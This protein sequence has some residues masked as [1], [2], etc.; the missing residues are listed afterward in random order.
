M[1]F[2]SRAH[3][4]ILTVTIAVLALYSLARAKTEYR[5]VQLRDKTK[6]EFAL[7]APDRIDPDASY[8]VLLALPPGPQHR[9]TVDWG[10]RNMYEKQ[11][12]KRGWI[13]VSPIAPNGR[14]FFSGSEQYIPELLALIAEEF[15]VAGGKFHVAGISNGGISVFRVVLDSPELFHSLIAMPGFP[16]GDD[17]KRLSRLKHLPVRMFVGQHDSGWVDAMQRSEKALR[18]M[19]TDVSLQ[20]VAGEGHQIGSL[21]GGQ[22]LFDLLDG[23]HDR[24]SRDSK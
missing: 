10:V 15:K 16:R 22:Q 24:V 4:T 11:A 18:D 17:F 3:T 6:L 20:V 14:L 8:P 1:H 7:V 9:G 13:V 5:T 21:Q 2:I 12:N 19:K 23:F